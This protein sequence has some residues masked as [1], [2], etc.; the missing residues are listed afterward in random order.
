[1]GQLGPCT[2]TR[3]QPPHPHSTHCSLRKPTCGSED[4]AQAEAE[5]TELLSTGQ[6][7][8]ALWTAGMLLRGD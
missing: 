2:A 1:M 6:T 8:A 5:E 7:S 4:P 3:E